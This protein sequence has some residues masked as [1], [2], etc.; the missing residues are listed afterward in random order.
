MPTGMWGRGGVGVEMERGGGE[1]HVCQGVHL[2]VEKHE[3]RASGK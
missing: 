1:L 3:Y 2:Y